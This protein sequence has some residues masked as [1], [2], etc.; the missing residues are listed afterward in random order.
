[1]PDRDEEFARLVVT[2]RRALLRYGIR[3]LDGPATAEDFVAETFVV[4]WRRFDELPRRE[5]EL[6]WLYG[7]G[8]RVIANL[9]RGRQRSMRLETRLAF[10]RDSGAEPRYSED[11]IEILMTALGY[12]TPDEREL[13][14]LVYWEKLSYREIGTALGCSEKAV[15]V[16]LSR[17]RARLRDLVSQHHSGAKVTPLFRE[18][19]N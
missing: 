15:G 9:Q 10:E 2:H 12:L 5:E 1:M 11:D 3:R 4:A 18:E 8:G 6:F 14:Q 19:T 17:A 7:I 16:R 13:I